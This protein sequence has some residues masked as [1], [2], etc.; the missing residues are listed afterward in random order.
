MI[1]FINLYLYK[2]Q[3]T[4]IYISNIYIIYYMIIIN[5]YNY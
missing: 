4:Y 1:V 3:L 2:Q 5:Y